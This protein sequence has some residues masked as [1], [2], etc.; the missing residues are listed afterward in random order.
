[1]YE[2][3][4]LYH[5]IQPI[6][7]SLGSP[8]LYKHSFQK[9]YPL[10]KY[11][12]DFLQVSNARNSQKYEPKRFLNNYDEYK[13]KEN[14]RS[15][16]NKEVLGE[17]IWDFSKDEILHLQPTRKAGFEH[18]IAKRVKPKPSLDEKESFISSRPLVGK[19]LKPKKMQWQ[20]NRNVLASP[21]TADYYDY[22]KQ[23]YFVTV[24]NY[25]VIYSGGTLCKMEI[26][27]INIHFIP[28]PSFYGINVKKGDLHNSTEVNEK[29][30]PQ[31]S[32]K[33][34]K[35]VNVEEKETILTTIPDIEDRT[36][37][38]MLHAAKVHSGMVNDRVNT[39]A[40]RK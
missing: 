36:F 1:M 19:L 31:A 18:K 26:C 29:A 33:A 38:T 16:I 37:K 39:I 22:N 9:V 5:I 4:P 24:P 14:Y 28:L 3:I 27:E 10:N 35:I 2:G 32:A 20:N 13:N 12:D 21:N 15:F 8:R 7:E 30:L 40:N 23:R 11:S 25:C 34:D 6:S 17:P